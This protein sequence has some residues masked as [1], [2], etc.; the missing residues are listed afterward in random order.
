MWR[1]KE[2]LSV[3]DALEALE[4]GLSVRKPGFNIYV[5]GLTGAGKMTTIK[6]ILEKL[7]VANS[8]PNDKCYVHNFRMPDMPGIIELPAGKGR[9]FKGDMVEA[10]FRRTETGN[11]WF[12]TSRACGMPVHRPS[13]PATP[14]FPKG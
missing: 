5:A 10:I 3:R 1:G 6:F 7:K 8:R 13:R 9:E 2:R 12:V 14:T 11:R 4:T